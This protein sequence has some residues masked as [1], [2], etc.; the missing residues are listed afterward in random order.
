MSG[1]ENEERKT[2][3]LS[4]GN[5]VE[6]KQRLLPENLEIELE[7]IVWLTWVESDISIGIISVWRLPIRDTANGDKTN[8]WFRFVLTYYR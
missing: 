2:K 8:D 1:S 4:G 3:Y 7:R 5:Q 6:R